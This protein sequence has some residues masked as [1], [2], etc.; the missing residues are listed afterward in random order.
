MNESPWNRQL[1]I[2]CNVL[3]PKSH[4]L[5]WKGIAV[6]G[7]SV[8]LEGLTAMVEWKVPWMGRT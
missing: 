8:L 2:P 7:D 1:I 3:G 5:V 6:Q 4:A